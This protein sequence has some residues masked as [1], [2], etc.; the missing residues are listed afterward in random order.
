[1][2]TANMASLGNLI[3]VLVGGF[4]HTCAPVAVEKE[5]VSRVPAP[6]ENPL[7]YGFNEPIRFGDLREGDITAATDQALEEAG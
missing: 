3:L 7:L 6:P 1:M 2:K 5:V 4:F